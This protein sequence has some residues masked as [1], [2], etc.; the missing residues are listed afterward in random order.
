MSGRDLL[1]GKATAYRPEPAKRGFAR[2]D[3]AGDQLFF[4]AFLRFEGFAVLLSLY[5]SMTWPGIR[6]RPDSS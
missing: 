5:A 6:P 1:P 3:Q 4:L 2:A